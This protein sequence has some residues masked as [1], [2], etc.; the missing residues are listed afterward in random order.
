[1]PAAPLVPPYGGLNMYSI[2]PGLPP[3]KLA[4]VANQPCADPASCFSASLSCSSSQ[5]ATSPDSIFPRRR[6]L[7]TAGGLPRTGAADR[8]EPCGERLATWS[9]DRLI[10]RLALV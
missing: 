1:M 10:A 8:E 3:C 4:V 7:Q 6:G 9:L 2:S 5:T